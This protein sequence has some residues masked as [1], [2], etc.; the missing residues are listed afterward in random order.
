[1]C[2][3][4][5]V[6]LINCTLCLWECVRKRNILTSKYRLAICITCVVYFAIG[7]VLVSSRLGKL[8]FINTRWRKK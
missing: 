3:L 2:N 7:N 1:M 4:K 6:Q 8:G 5:F